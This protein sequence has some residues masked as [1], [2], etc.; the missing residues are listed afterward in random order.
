LKII[1]W[2]K[3]KTTVV[4]SVGILVAMGTTVAVMK[5][6]AQTDLSEDLVAREIQDKSLLPANDN[7]TRRQLQGSWIITDKRFQGNRRFTHYP[8]N[9]PHLKTWTLTN[10]AI[11]TYNAKSNVVYSASGPYEIHC[12]LYTETVK[13][14]TGNMTNYIGT[15]MQYKL[16]VKGDRYYQMGSGIEET[17]QRVQ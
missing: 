16:R 17:G 3:M 12:D 14:G 7:E 1:G 13:S 9:N 8:T 15:R 2:T 11:V 10:W 4:S 6:K 5:A